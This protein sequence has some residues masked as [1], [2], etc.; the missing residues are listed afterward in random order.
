[1]VFV[2]QRI[3]YILLACVMAL[4]VMLVAPQLY[5]QVQAGD[6]PHGSY[7]ITPDSCAACHMTHTARSDEIIRSSTVNDLCLT[8]HDGSG[9]TKAVSTHSNASDGHSGHRTQPLFT[10]DCTEC[11]NPHGGQ[12]NLS[13]IRG[14]IRDHE[15]VFLNRTGVDSFDEAE[16][17]AGTP[18]AS[19]Y[20]DICATCHTQT[21]HNNVDMDL[22]PMDKGHWEGDDCI[23][24]H[25]HD[26]DGDP[27]TDDG[28]MRSMGGGGH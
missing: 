21:S 17:P 26:P 2:V 3:L 24:C 10:L 27:S 9:S 8:C 12:D 11:H 5:M 28:F 6:N 15:V 25:S 19:N 7:S 1:M 4:G 20:D 14:E 23:S 16:D 22:G 18:D 13:L